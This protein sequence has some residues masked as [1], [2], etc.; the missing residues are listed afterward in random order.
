MGSDFSMPRLGKF[1]N[2]HKDDIIMAK[3][4]LRVDALGDKCSSCKP[5]EWK[6]NCEKLFSC[7]NDM[8]EYGKTL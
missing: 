6:C 3:H 4:Q 8:T 5:N 1:T 2:F 7:V